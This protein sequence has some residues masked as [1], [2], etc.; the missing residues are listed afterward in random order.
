MPI[1]ANIDIDTTIN[2]LW[3]K[4]DKTIVNSDRVFISELFIDSTKKS[5]SILII[6]SL[7]ITFD[8]ANFTCNVVIQSNPSSFY[9]QDSMMVAESTYLI[10]TGK[11]IVFK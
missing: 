10:V 2:V 4:N 5:Q 6:K 3:K 7:S 1:V 8:S 9:V 11:Q